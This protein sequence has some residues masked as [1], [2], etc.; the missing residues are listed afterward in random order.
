MPPSHNDIAD[1]ATPES[2]PSSPA[3]RHLL[4]IDGSG[5][6]FRAFYGLPSMTDNR[7]FPVGAIFGFCRMLLQTLEDLHA[8]NGCIVVF[9]C[10]RRTFRNDIYPDYKA[11][12]TTP[13]E[14]LA[15]QFPI[16]KTI[17]P[18]FGLPC[19]EKEGFE[20]DDIIASYA[21]LARNDHIDV[22]IV[23]SDKDLMQ[24][25]RPGVD[26]FDPVKKQRIDKSGVVKKFGVHPDKVVDVQSLA[27][28]ASDNVPGVPGIGLKTAATLINQFGN[29]DNLLADAL[30]ITQ[31]KRRQSLLDHADDARLSRRLCR[32]HDQI[33]VDVHWDKMRAT[34]PEKKPLLDFLAEFDLRRIDRDARRLFFK[35]DEDRAGDLVDHPSSSSAKGAEKYTTIT[36][37]DTLARQLTILQRQGRMAFDTETD[38]LDPRQA[39]LV[40]VSFAG[41]DGRAFYVPFRHR[42][43]SDKPDSAPSTTAP[44]KEGIQ[45]GTQEKDRH[46]AA[47][48]D[49]G[50]APSPTPPTTEPFIPGQIALEHGLAL[51]KPILEDESVLKI[52]QNI[53][54]DMQVMARHSIGIT[55]L[56]DT[57]LLSWCSG[58]GVRGHTLENIAERVLD[59]TMISFTDVVGSG[60]HQRRFDQVP[61]DQA[62]QYAAED[63]DVTR[64]AWEKLIPMLV[65]SRQASVYY[66]M[67]RPLVGIL[68]RMEQT[69]ILVDKVKLEALSADF[70]RRLTRL[71][72]DI[73]QMAGRPFTI[74]SPKQLSHILYEEMGL[75]PAAKGKSGVPSTKADVLEDLADQGHQLPRKVLEWRHLSKL[76]G[77]YT[78]ALVADIDPTTGRVHTSFSMT[79]TSTGRLASSDPNLQNIPVRSEEGRA[80]RAAFIA[81]KGHTLLSADYS[82]IEL[83]LLAHVADIATMKKAF[84][85]GRDIH[86]V[87]AAQIF[88]GQPDTIDPLIRRRAKAINFGIIYGISPFGLARQLDVSRSEAKTYID[89]FMATYPGIRAYMERTIAFCREHGYVETP[90]KRRCYMPD[91][92]H[93]T[94]SRRNF[95]ERAAINAPLQGGGADLIKRAMIRIDHQL[96]RHGMKSRMMLQVHD[97]LVFE[98]PDDERTRMEAMVLE[99]MRLAG[100]PLIHFQ[101]EL[102]I[103]IAC[104]DNWRD[105][106]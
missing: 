47:M 14:D 103:H 13:P 30:S 43:F 92:R 27:G 39:N 54:F 73:H 69:G 82:Q 104:A 84:A 93:R 70:L 94:P 20:A 3:I 25:V 96:R 23:S 106:H 60:K 7:G 31:P 48:L 44:E 8:D 71:E 46:H 55:P 35:N 63:A 95:A 51:L 65:K 90:F 15:K 80:I 16:I 102:M 99:Q 76:R 2:S 41:S 86:A 74:G 78:Q 59:R 9:D 97:E 85:E 56:D 58:E 26:M 62:T 68:A 45:E 105:A 5:Y 81:A 75:K 36:D 40:G 52:G 100:A 66:M 18:L 32:L 11:N 64:R 91:I 72:A 28:D 24:L 22:T 42:P 79:A 10:A 6:I 101:P 21:R 83:R 77:T 19:I 57:C 49:L 38:G 61:I 88:G 34:P 53:K 98:V 1:P 29:L 67:E 17:P 12:R 4:L 37:T 50:P 33:A 89:A 87:T